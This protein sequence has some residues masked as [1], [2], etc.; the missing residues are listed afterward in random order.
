MAEVDLTLH[1]AEGVQGLPGEG[2][3]GGAKQARTRNK[4]ERAGGALAH[5]QPMSAVEASGDGGDARV[6]IV[7]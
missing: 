1:A 7:L 4:R 3:E 6:G 2:G 5:G